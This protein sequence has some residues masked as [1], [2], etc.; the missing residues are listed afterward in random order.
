[1]WMMG[2]L[3]S[4]V[5]AVTTENLF[6]TSFNIPFNDSGSCQSVKYKSK[7]VACKVAPDSTSFRA[8]LLL[9]LWIKLPAPA[10]HP[11]GS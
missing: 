2:P 3:R 11:P 7:V 4:L 1:M 5:C 10:L 8:L 6:V 9:G